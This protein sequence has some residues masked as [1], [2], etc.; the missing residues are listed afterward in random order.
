MVVSD[1]AGQLARCLKL[2]NLSDETLIFTNPYPTV[3]F[4]FFSAFA[5]KNYS[6]NI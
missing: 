6:I 5:R 2:Q 1:S 4:S 3:V